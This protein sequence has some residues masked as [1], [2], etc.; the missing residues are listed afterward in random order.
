MKM[1]ARLELAAVGLAH[2]RFMNSLAQNLSRRAMDLIRDPSCWTQS[3]AAR[4]QRSRPVSPCSADACAFCG[5][6]ALTKAAQEWG[7]SEWLLPE[8]FGS[9]ALSHLIR[10]NDSQTHEAVLACLCDLGGVHLHR[11]PPVA[12]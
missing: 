7:L 8:I 4:D 2:G 12:E 9:A 10:V 11:G 1:G 5:F 3:V 6:G